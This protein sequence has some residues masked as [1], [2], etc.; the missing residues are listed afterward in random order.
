MR[1]QER[2]HLPLPRQREGGDPPGPLHPTAVRPDPPQ[3]ERDGLR[4]AHA[5]QLE[6][7]P[8]E[9]DVVAEPSG[10]LSRVSVAVDVHQQP[11]E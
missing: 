3:Q 5:E 11:E 10:L 8:L 6:Q 2:D 1:L 9:A 7:I 4:R